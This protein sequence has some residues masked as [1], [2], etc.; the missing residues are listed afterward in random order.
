MT[1][2][3]QSKASY[4][5]TT[6]DGG[7]IAAFLGQIFPQHPRQYH[8]YPKLPAL[9]SFEKNTDNYRLGAGYDKRF[10]IK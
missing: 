3:L 10:N 9:S 8:R 4:N 5:Y 2:S 6:F 7:H 1:P